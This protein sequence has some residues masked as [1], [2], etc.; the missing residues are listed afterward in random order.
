MNLTLERGIEAATAGQPIDLAPGSEEGQGHGGRGYIDQNRSECRELRRQRM[1]LW[2][3]HLKGCQAGEEHDLREEELG[4]IRRKLFWREDVL[5]QADLEAAATVRRQRLMEE[6]K[7]W[8]LRLCHTLAFVLTVVF[9]V[10]CV[11]ASIYVIHPFMVTMPFRDTKCHV[12]N[13]TKIGREPIELNC[14]HVLL[15][16]N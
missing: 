3:H 14:Q 2:E 12:I 8:K 9:L 13:V 4:K 7:R 5:R 10:P 11:L 6:R 1:Q 15:Y 16:Y